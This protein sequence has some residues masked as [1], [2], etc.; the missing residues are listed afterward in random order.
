LFFAVAAAAA[1]FE[2]PRDVA[3]PVVV[4]AMVKAQQQRNTG[5]ALFAIVGNQIKKL[6]EANIE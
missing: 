3:P 4:R 2:A 5:A 1:T 6:T